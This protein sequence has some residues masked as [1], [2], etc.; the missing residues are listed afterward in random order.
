MSIYNQPLL[1]TFSDK[2]DTRSKLDF[3]E[4]TYDGVIVDWNSLPKSPIDFMRVL[5]TSLSEWKSQGKKGVWMAIPVER[6]DL[7]PVAIKHG[8]KP[9]H[10]EETHIV[11]TT[12]LSRPPN[13]L[14]AQAAHYVGVGVAVVNAAGQLLVVQEKNGPLRGRDYWKVPTGLVNTNEDILTAAVREVKEET[15]VD[16]G[17]EGIFALRETHLQGVQKKTDLFFLC[18][19]YAL[20]TEITI[21]PEELLKATWMDIPEYLGLAQW[22]EGTAPSHLNNILVEHVRMNGQIKDSSHQGLMKPNKLPRR[23]LSGEFANVHSVPLARL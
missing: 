18:K 13:A 16:I 11:F 5:R 17:V 23:L 12:W 20:N 6:A 2:Q 1:L 3:K 8:F 4:D 19:A 10:S 21:D 14:P 7:I 9:H 15:G 22:K